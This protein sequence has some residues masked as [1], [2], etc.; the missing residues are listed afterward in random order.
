MFG[1]VIVVCENAPDFVDV[2]VDNNASRDST[3]V[4]RWSLDYNIFMTTGKCLLKYLTVSLAKFYE[5]N[6][7]EAPNQQ[8][9]ACR[10]RCS[11]TCDVPKLGD[12]K[13][14]IAFSGL[15][16]AGISTVGALIRFTLLGIW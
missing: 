14:L 12:E 13:K 9:A 1:E 7:L 4:K 16:V 11:I 15:N 2:S 10:N 3:G 5:N 8:I 6:N